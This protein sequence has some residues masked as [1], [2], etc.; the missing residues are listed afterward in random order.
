MPAKPIDSDYDAA[1]P[2][3]SAATMDALG[4]WAVL[5]DSAF[6]V[7]GTNVRFG[8]DAIIGLVPGLGDLVAPIFTVILLGTALKMR[9]RAVTTCSSLAAS[10]SSS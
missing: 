8:L 7:P 10:P 3:T 4:R 2:P 9:R 1:V 6:K 5:L